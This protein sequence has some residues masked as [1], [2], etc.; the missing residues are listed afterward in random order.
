MQELLV[1]SD[2]N[3]NVSCSLLK[4][5][6]THLIYLSKNKIL[7]I[8]KIPIYNAKRTLFYKS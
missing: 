4:L 8:T 7:V 2:L 5:K 6:F 3:V 1:F